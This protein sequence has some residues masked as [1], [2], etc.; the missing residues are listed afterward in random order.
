MH[1]EPELRRFPQALL[2]LGLR[3]SFRLFQ[4]PPGSFTWWDYRQAGFS[5]NQGLRIDHVLA[6]IPLA[7]ACRS[8]T[9][10]LEPRR[11]ERPSDHTR[12]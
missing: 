9:I 11:V 3:D 1:S 4:Q 8:S 10:D 7:A 6:S 5:R 12:P 2:E